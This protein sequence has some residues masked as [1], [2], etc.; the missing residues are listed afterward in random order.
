[1]RLAAQLALYD[2]A[3]ARGDLYVTCPRCNGNRTVTACTVIGNDFVPS[4][5]EDFPCP[6]CKEVGS[7]HHDEAGKYLQDLREA[8]EF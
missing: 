5:Y 7:I 2:Q 4:R 6:L 1:M 8:E 3:V